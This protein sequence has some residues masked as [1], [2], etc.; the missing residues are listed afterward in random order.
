[1]SEV[2]GG[3]LLQVVET[4]FDRIPAARRADAFR[5]NS[6]GWDHQLVNIEQHVAKG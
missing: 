5:M 1:L 2:A 6:G 4:G 3:T